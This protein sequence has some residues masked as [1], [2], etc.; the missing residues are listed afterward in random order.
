M[1]YD[2]N[3]PWTPNTAEL[4]RTLAFLAERTVPISYTHLPTPIFTQ[5]LT[6]STQSTTTS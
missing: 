5:P 3:V 4:Q 2:L 6:Q 1:F